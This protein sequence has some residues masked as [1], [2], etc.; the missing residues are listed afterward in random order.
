MIATVGACRAVVVPNAAASAAYVLSSCVGPTEHCGGD[1]ATCGGVHCG[2]GLAGRQHFPPNF[3]P[4]LLFHGPLAYAAA[5]EHR[6][7]A[8][9]DVLAQAGGGVRDLGLV[10]GHHLHPH[11]V[12]APAAGEV[13]GGERKAGWEG[14]LWRMRRR[15][16]RPNHAH[17][18]H[19]CSQPASQWVFVSAT[20]PARISEPTTRAAASGAG[21]SGVPPT[22]QDARACVARAPAWGLPRQRRGVVTAA[23]RRDPRAGG[24]GVAA[25]PRAA[26]GLARPWARPHPPAHR[27]CAAVRDSGRRTGKT[28]G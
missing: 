3:Q 5:D 27:P 13:G 26:C 6:T 10:V 8:R 1:P 12:H 9:A 23:A 21:A 15:P 28:A 7:P 18:T 24:I 19:P 2:G 16:P 4:L 14:L 25:R 11:Q 22:P 17:P 20:D